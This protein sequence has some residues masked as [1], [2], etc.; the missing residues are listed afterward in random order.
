VARPTRAELSAG[1]DAV[2]AGIPP[3][4]LGRIVSAAR[5]SD[6]AVAMAVLT[7]L[8]REEGI[9]VE[10]A[11][12]RVTAAMAQG[13]QALRDLPARSAAAA[14]TARRGPGAAGAAG[15]P[16]ADANRQPGAGQRP[17]VVRPGNDQPAEQ[18]PTRPGNRP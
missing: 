14:A 10:A 16:P 5:S 9:P 17:G 8:H 7:Y 1:A 13:P 2:E 11:L 6:R 18:R 12:D 15:R 3:H 4:I